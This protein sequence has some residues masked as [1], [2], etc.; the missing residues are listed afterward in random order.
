MKLLLGKYLIIELSAERS[1]AEIKRPILYY[2]QCFRNM[3]T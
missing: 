1:K 2:L 3:Y